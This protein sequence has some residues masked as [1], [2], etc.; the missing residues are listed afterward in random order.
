MMQSAE[1]YQ[2]RDRLL[3][4]PWQQT[5]DGLHFA[6]EPYISLPLD[7]DDRTLG[8]SVLEALSISGRTVA[9]PASWKEMQAV[10]LKAAGVKSERTFQSGARSV[11]V[12][13]ERDSFRIEPTRNGG[14]RGDSKGFTPLPERSSSIP[15]SSSPEGLGAAVRAGFQSCE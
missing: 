13:R 4:H 9:H 8:N 5:R 3:I 14:T 10:R 15:Q 6:S 1:V 12:E 7:V 2:L 11:H